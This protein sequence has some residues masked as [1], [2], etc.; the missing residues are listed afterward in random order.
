MNQFA[1]LLTGWTAG[2]AGA[3]L[4]AIWE[5]SLLAGGVWLIVRFLPGLTAAARSVIWLN[6]FILMS[7]LHLVP[8][9]TGTGAPEQEMVPHG[10][11]LDPR[12]SLLIGA[13]W[14]ALSIFRAGQLMAG[15]L[16]LRRLSKRAEPLPETPELKVLLQRNEKQV[17]LCTSAD[18]ARPSVLGFFR[19]RILMPPDL[20]DRLTPAE[21]KQVVLHEMEH[22]RRGDDWTNLI[23]KLALVLFPLNPALAWVER[24]LCAERELAC[25]DRVLHAGS[26]R[27][28]YALCL[29]HL[30]EYALVRR[31][32]G[33]VLGA[34]ERR[35][36]LVR[37]VQRI[38][39]EPV[40]KMGRGPALAA[41][42]GLVAGALGC[43]LV[44]AH[45]P[46]MVSFAP[47]TLTPA[48]M[49]AS[50]D[51]SQVAKAL[52]GR[53]EMVKAVMPEANERRQVKLQRAVPA[54]VRQPLRRGAPIK[55]QDSRLAEL[56]MPPPPAM[57]T[58]MVMTEWTE[59][60]APPQVVVALARLPQAAPGGK[61][62]VPAIRAVFAVFR[63]PSGW[64]VVQI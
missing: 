30:A 48:Q 25:D 47:A 8:L 50:L 37:R 35:P 7:L 34:W 56:R 22:L 11:R 4:A 38:L 23:Q 40:Q 36:E 24:R 12:W 2:A 6:V 58:A 3:L 31:G 49:A 5:G 19:P 26:G 17:A 46:E 39:S 52:G 42:G 59:V 18:V 62:S 10:V 33:L 51:P 28:A 44:L 27:K 1:A 61:K 53:A 21:L 9:F 16:H 20:V 29:A 32:F 45:M 55:D 43:A 13:L 41:T 54:V 14:L 63:T 60:P 64:L 57:S 15:A